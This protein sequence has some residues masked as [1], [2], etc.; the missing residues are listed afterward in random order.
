MPTTVCFAPTGTVRHA[1]RFALAAFALLLLGTLVPCH[2]QVSWRTETLDVRG[3]AGAGTAA[4]RD[5]LGRTHISYTAEETLLRSRLVHAVWDGIAWHMETVADDAVFTDGTDVAVA[6]DGTVYVSYVHR[7]GAG[8]PTPGGDLRLARRTASGWQ[9]EVVVGAP[10]VHG[11]QNRLAIGPNGLHIT[12]VSATGRLLH[13]SSN[14]VGWNPPVE[15]GQS[16]GQRHGLAVRSDG[17]LRV[18]Y[19]DPGAGGHLR[20]GTRPAGDSPWHTGPVDSDPGSGRYNDLALDGLGRPYIAYT[21]GDGSVRLAIQDGPTWSLET[22]ALPNQAAT[23]ISVAVDDPP[24]GVG[25][26][27]VAFRDAGLGLRIARRNLGGGPWQVE[28][29]DDTDIAGTEA[30]LVHDS[31]GEP[32]IAHHD[33]YF[34]SVKFS[35]Q[36]DRWRVQPLSF[37]Q[38]RLWPRLAMQRG[39]PLVASANDSAVPTVLDVLRRVVGAWVADLVALI[40]STAH[41]IAFEVDGDGGQHTVWYNTLGRQYRYGYQSPGSGNWQVETLATL[42]AGWLPGPAA[43][44]LRPLSNAANVFLPSIDPQGRNFQVGVFAKA[45]A[46]S[47]FVRSNFVSPLDSI[48]TLQAFAAAV[49]NDGSTL[50][51]ISLSDR[52]GVLLVESVESGWSQQL[53]QLPAAPPLLDLAMH[54]RWRVG[55]TLNFVGLAFHDPVNDELVYAV[56]DGETGT[57]VQHPVATASAPRELGLAL[58]G[59]TWWKPR[60]AWLASD[61][62]LELAVADNLPGPFL[63]ETVVAAPVGMSPSGGDGS[64]GRRSLNLRF[65]DRE[66]IL[67]QEP[68][69]QFYVAQR[70]ESRLA[71]PAQTASGGLGATPLASGACFCVFFGSGQCGDCDCCLPV[72]HPSCCQQGSPHWPGCIGNRTDAH[73]APGGRSRSATS[74]SDASGDGR[75]LADLTAQ[76]Q[77][78]SQGQQWVAFF[79]ANDRELF[80]ILLRDPVLFWDSYRVLHKMVPGLK[81]LTEGRGHEAVISQRLMQFA[82]SIWLRV[83]DAASPPF[84]SAILGYLEDYDMLQDFVGMNYAQFAI[85][86]GVDPAAVSDLVFA[87]GF[88]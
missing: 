53:L 55:G 44:R 63:V 27:Q 77:R 2:A 26:I 82:A 86:L 20:H 72:H 10:G 34:G 22:V 11:R 62:A 70:S 8:S 5:S 38:G 24:G 87:D 85:T 42:P 47:P 58:G 59:G 33:P 65:D 37:G 39:V 15:I 84:R 6:F 21:G 75:V 46:A 73:H 57:W 18:S 28:T 56:R 48:P 78:T 32:M 69:E 43:L 17:V 66:R 80:E 29:V 1:L 74:A 79:R 54:S 83:A 36:V 41:S 13:V 3:R 7:H 14:V 50:L 9:R 51:A 61:G 23:W 19:F 4:T 60:L 25:E 64:L 49:G 35:S 76:F 16:S 31:A 30:T 71:A 45:D 81:A 52:S 88:E 12:Y 67:F 68:D 40:P